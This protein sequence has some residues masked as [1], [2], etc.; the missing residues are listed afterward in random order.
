MENLGVDMSIWRMFMTV[1]LHAA[2]H[3]GNDHVENLHCTKNQPKRT[4]KQVF[5]VKRKL[6]KDQNEIQ[7]ISVISW[8]QQTWQRTTLLEA[9]QLSN[10]KTLRILRLSVVCGRDQ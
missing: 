1:T 5:N 7:G 4:L 3:L 9:V 6:I 8:Q 2:V 10:A